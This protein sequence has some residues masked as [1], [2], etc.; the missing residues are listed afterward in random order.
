MTAVPTLIYFMTLLSILLIQIVLRV[1]S[2]RMERGL[3]RNLLFCEEVTNCLMRTISR[4]VPLE[5]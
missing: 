4:I 1:V 2:R 5:E 3:I